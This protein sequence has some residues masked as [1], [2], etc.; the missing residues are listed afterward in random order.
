MLIFVAACEGSPRPST[1]PPTASP[2]A[3]TSRGADTPPPLNRLELKVVDALSRLGIVGQRAQLPFENASIYAQSGTAP[4][5]F[6]NAWPPGS[7][8]DEFT[9]VD[10]RQL[11]GVHVDRIRYSTIPEPVYRFACAQNTYEVS[12]TPPPTFEDMDT[13]VSR[14][15]DAL[16]RGI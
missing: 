2:G 12:G 1:T 13:F 6:V 4:P 9:V 7:S 3:E 5:L 14:L 16:G 8:H 11:S 15:I 10:Q